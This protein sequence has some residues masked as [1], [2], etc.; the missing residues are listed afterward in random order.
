MTTIIGAFFIGRKHGIELMELKLL[1][2]E[3]KQK[4]AEHA[5]Q[6]QLSKTAKKADNTINNSDI[7]NELRAEGELR[8]K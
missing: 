8:A 7:V 4:E 3:A 6:N 5:L 1:K 2:S